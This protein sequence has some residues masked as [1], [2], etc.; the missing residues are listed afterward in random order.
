MNRQT[1]TGS[2]SFAKKAAVPSTRRRNVGS[3]LEL[4]VLRW[5]ESGSTRRGS[6]GSVGSGASRSARSGGCS[7]ERP[8]DHCAI[9]QL[10]GVAPPRATPSRLALTL[11]DVFCMVA[12][13]MAATAASSVIKCLLSKYF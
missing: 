9:R 3:V 2:P 4:E 13:S 11:R 8:A 1:L 10:G 5:R 12:S 6:G 7:I